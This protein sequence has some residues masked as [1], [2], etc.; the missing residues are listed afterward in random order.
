[1]SALRILA[2]IPVLLVA[3]CASSPEQY[4][5]A[6]TECKVVPAQFVNSPKKNATDAEKAEAQLKFQRFAYARGGYGVGT[7]M[8]AEAIRNCY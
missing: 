1:M 6:P 7:N 5:S 3:A 4:A 2:L 8:P